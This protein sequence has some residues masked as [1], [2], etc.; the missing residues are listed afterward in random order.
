VLYTA[1]P[2]GGELRTQPHETIEVA[3]FPFDRLP[4]ELLFGHRK[5]IQDAIHGTSAVSVRQ[6]MKTS[7]SK[8]HTRKEIYEARDRSGLSRREFYVQQFDD[9][10]INEVVEVGNS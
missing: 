2:I 5:R 6:E 7:D 8:L 3:Y 1:K 10:E 9:A 4:N